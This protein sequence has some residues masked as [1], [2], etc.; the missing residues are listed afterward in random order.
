MDLNISNLVQQVADLK[1]RLERANH[2]YGVIFDAYGLAERE[3]ALL[4]SIV[5]ASYYAP[6]EG[7]NVPVFRV[8]SVEMDK[9]I[10]DWL[11]KNGGVR[12]I[13]KDKRKP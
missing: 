7:T 9:T 2:E 12:Y 1:R 11:L 10:T 8:P 6:E 13:P 4:R 5:L 3:N